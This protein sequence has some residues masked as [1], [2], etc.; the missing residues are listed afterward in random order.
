VATSSFTDAGA[1]PV[2]DHHW[3]A[4]RRLQSGAQLTR[5]DVDQT[6]AG[7]RH[8]DADRPARPGL[9]QGRPCGA[10]QRR[11]QCDVLSNQTTVHGK[12]STVCGR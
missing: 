9:R 8:D 12:L 4:Q 5:G 7:P 1:W 2:V 11:S 6:T 10:T 3:L